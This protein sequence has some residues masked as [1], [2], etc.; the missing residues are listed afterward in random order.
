M[1]N[2]LVLPYINGLIVNTKFSNAIVIK[3]NNSLRKNLDQIYLKQMINLTYWDSG[4]ADNMQL[5]GWKGR[6]TAVNTPILN[7]I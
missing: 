4:R 6:V 3:N 5:H 2:I 1:L 7:V